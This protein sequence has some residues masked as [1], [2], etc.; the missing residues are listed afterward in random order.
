MAPWVRYSIIRVGLFALLFTIVLLLG[1]ELW[2]S[3]LVATLMAFSLSY[4]FF[5]RQRDL[6]ARDIATRV[7]RKRHRDADTIAEDD[8]TSSEGDSPR[9]P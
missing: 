4:I 8:A 6:L 5:S 2:I 3:A 9:Q 7:E 1:I